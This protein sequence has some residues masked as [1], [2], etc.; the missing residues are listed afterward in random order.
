LWGLPLTETNLARIGELRQLRRLSL[1]AATLSD[2]GVDRP[3]HP[4]AERSELA[5]LSALARLDQ[6]VY[7]DLTKQPVTPGALKSVAALPAL[8]EL[9]L[10]LAKALDASTVTGLRDRGVVVR[11]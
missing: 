9:R 4:E 10:G 7:L 11:Q 8:R 6:L 3:G 5:D 1:A 2:R